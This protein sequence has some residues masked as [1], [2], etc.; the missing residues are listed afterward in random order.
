MS[1]AARNWADNCATGSRLAKSVLLVLANAAT[2]KLV[3]GGHGAAH[4]CTSAGH[5]RQADRIQRPTVQRALRTLN[6]VGRVLKV[7]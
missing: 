6:L 5:H 2:E 3:M 4:Q 1:V 7:S